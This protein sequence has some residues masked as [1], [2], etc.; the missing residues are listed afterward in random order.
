MHKQHHWIIRLWFQPWLQSFLLLQGKGTSNQAAAEAASG[1]ASG[2]SQA[3][4]SGS[5]AQS[6]NAATAQQPYMGSNYTLTGSVNSG[7]QPQAGTGGLQP[8]A[9]GSN[10]RT[11]Q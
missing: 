2:S 4:S 11:M 3:Q 8:Q 10:M 6:G 7:F 9:E 5:T 1:N